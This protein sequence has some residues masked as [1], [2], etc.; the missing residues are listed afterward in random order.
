MVIV[1]IIVTAIAATTTTTIVIVPD[2]MVAFLL[3][4]G[5]VRN[6]CAIVYSTNDGPPAACQ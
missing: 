2:I 6:V 1:I 3:H 4:T 5:V